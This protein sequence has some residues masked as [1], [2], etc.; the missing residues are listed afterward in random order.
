VYSTEAPSGALRLYSHQ[1]IRRQYQIIAVMCLVVSVAVGA[2]IANVFA[3]ALAEAPATFVFI[4]LAAAGPFAITAWFAY[5]LRDNVPDIEIA[6]GMLRLPFRKHRERQGWRAVAEVHL[7]AQHMTVEAKMAADAIVAS[8]RVS[9]IAMAQ[10][11]QMIGFWAQGRSLLA[12]TDDEVFILRGETSVFDQLI[13]HWDLERRRLAQVV[14][15]PG[16][17]ALNAP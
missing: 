12:I 4:V 6:P 11:K 5:R 3:F 1:R 16:T 15:P 13:A 7:L 2:I 10:H 8:M 9:R 17:A 14:A